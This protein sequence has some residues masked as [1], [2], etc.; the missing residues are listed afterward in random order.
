MVIRQLSRFVRQIFRSEQASRR[1]LL[2]AG[3]EP[4]GRVSHNDA[5]TKVAR[6]SNVSDS[7]RKRCDAKTGNRD[8]LQLFARMTNQL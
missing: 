4:K 7:S 6:G 5:L 3:R 2:R 1:A 8:A